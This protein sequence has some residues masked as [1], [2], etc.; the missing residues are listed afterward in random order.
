[1]YVEAADFLAASG[2]EQYEI[3]NFARPG[4]EARHN[5]KYWKR[6]P[7]LGVGL[8]AH[9]MLRDADGRALRFATTDSLEPFLESA[10]WKR[11]APLT[12]EEELEEAW[13]LGLR[14]NV[15]V[16]LPALREEFGADAASQF[17]SAIAELA[18][19]SLI[20]YIDE[21]VR[22]TLRGRLLSN[23][24]FARFLGEPVNA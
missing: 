14:L 9:S 22:L 8:D 19:D 2:L 17:D 18:S 15:G 21:Q 5:L 10:R 13:F 12:R 7:Y 16:S 3:S 4:A 24:V 23:E 11:P 1:M 20:E 6:R